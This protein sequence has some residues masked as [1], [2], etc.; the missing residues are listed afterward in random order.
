MSHRL[1]VAAVIAFL[2][3]GALACA[4]DAPPAPAAE[5]GASAPSPDAATLYAFGRDNPDCREWSNACQTCARDDR[6]AAQCSTAG[7]ACTPQPPVCK[8]GAAK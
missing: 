2:A 7:I 8:A 3:F 4:Q 6:G 1:P 5:S